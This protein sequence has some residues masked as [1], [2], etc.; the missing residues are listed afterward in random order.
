MATAQELVGWAQ[1]QIGV[2]ES[3]ANSNRVKYWDYYRERCGLNLQGNPWCVA[4]V[5]MGMSVIGQ[6][7]FT[8]DEPRF[9][10]CP[11][12]VDWAKANGQWL[13]REAICQPGDLILF[14]DS[15]RAC[16][17]GIVE[18]RIS[19]A[20]VQTIEGN[21]SVTSNDNGGS[22]M[23]RIRTYGKAG[24]S[25]YILGFVRS[26]WTEKQ[27]ADV[28]HQVPGNKVNNN[29]FYYRAQ[30]Q[31]L[32]WLEAVSD[33]QTAG[34]VGY[35]K[36]LEAFKLNPPEGLELEVSVNIQ[37]I[38]WRTYSG[39]K[40]GDRSGT[41]SSNNDPII[42]TV[43]QSRRLEAIQVRAT[44]NTTGKNL[45]YR[46]HAQGVGWTDWVYAPYA[47]GSVGFSNRLE[48]IQFVLE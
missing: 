30:V 42:G 28:P 16:H 4:F 38:G 23:R 31:S 37:G 36:R 1:S 26:K 40:A 32:G 17:V 46:V 12:L 39:I 22:V 18:K 10:Y 45:K 9:R 6:W 8:K 48:A 43:G 19:S 29:G 44:K 24:S 3:P 20:E 47:T 7:S 34:T 13:D 25:W 41:G 5:T 21:T 15:T 14:S 33:G 27:P 11:A 2:K 35:S